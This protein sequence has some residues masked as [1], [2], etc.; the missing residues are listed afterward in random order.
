MR[1]PPRR[2]ISARHQRS[3]RKTAEPKWQQ[4]HHLRLLCHQ[5][6]RYH[7]RTSNK[8]TPFIVYLHK[9]GNNVTGKYLGQEAPRC[10]LKYSSNW[11]HGTNCGWQRKPYNR[12]ICVYNN[13][14]AIESVVR[15]IRLGLVQY[16]GGTKAG[17]AGST[18]HGRYQKRPHRRPPSASAP[19]MDTVKR[20]MNS[21]THWKLSV[22]CP[23]STQIWA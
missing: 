11:K 16:S 3:K 8:Y 18:D 20:A 7:P 21:P 6:E 13:V 23:T 4:D 12:I 22:V 1:Y 14:R 9:Q 17:V 15:M 19:L 10:T 2:P 5:Y